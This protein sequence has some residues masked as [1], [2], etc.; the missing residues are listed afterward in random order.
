MPYCS[1]HSW[2]LCTHVSSPL[3]V[4]EK[5]QEIVDNIETEL[6]NHSYGPAALPAPTAS[7]S[8][9]GQKVSGFTVAML[10]LKFGCSP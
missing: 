10:M 2:L 8:L 5:A 4:Q 7:V 3:L 9:P 6:E 1:R